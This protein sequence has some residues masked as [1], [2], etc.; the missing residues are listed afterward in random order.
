MDKMTSGG[1][2]EPNFYPWIFFKRRILQI[3]PFY[4]FI[5][6]N[7]IFRERVMVPHILEISASQEGGV[8]PEIKMS[9]PG[10]PDPAPS[11][12]KFN[13]LSLSKRKKEARKYS[14]IYFDIWFKYLIHK[15][16]ECR[17]AENFQPKT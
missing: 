5:K 7:F 12:K 17:Q 10:Q 6:N 15:I 1:L 9:K 16:R 14:H 4:L 2:R 3:A 11:G 8:I 13:R